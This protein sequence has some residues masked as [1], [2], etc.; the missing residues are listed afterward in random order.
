[1]RFVYCAASIC[2]MLDN[3]GTVDKKSMA[4]YILN[5]IVSLLNKKNLVL[6]SKS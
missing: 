2:A 5:S 1:M 6:K 4:Q 3:W